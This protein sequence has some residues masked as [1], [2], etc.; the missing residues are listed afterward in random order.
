MRLG[1]RML[2]AGGLALPFSTSAQTP[3]LRALARRAAVFLA[4]LHA[5]YT[6]RHRDVVE[7]GQKLNKLARQLSPQNHVLPA[8][9]WLDLSGEPMFLTLPPMSG[10]PYGV[11]LVDPFGRTVAALDRAHDGDTPQPRILMG[12][13][14]Q[15]VAPSEAAAIHT[16]ARSVRLR[17]GLAVTDDDDELDDARGVQ[18]RTLLETPD[19]RNQRRILEMQELMRFR[20]DLPPEPVADW[21]PPRPGT[22]FDLFETGLAMLG[23]CTLSERDRQVLEELA[24]LRLRAGRRFDARAFGEAERAAIAEGIVDS[25]EEIAAAKAALDAPIRVG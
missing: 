22:P 2:V 17:Y 18:A 1:R 13:A 12:P 23:D 11:M 10:R 24:P 14:W 9:A 25:S 16:P 6:R 7:R 21:D 8:G 4:P 20:T 19:E 15:G 5:A 3:D